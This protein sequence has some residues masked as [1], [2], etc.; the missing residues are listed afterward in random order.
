MLRP[1]I[2]PLRRALLIATTALA[3]Y[4]RP[5][6]QGDTGP[7]GGGSTGTGSSSDT[8][9][10]GDGATTA[11]DDTGGPATCTDDAAC[12]DGSVCSDDRCVAGAC[13][14]EP[15][16]APGCT[17]AAVDDC[18]Q[19]PASDECR[20][21]QCIDGACV[22]ELADLGTA[23]PSSQQQDGD[24]QRAVCDGLGGHVSET[25]DDDVPIDGLECTADRCTAGTPSNPPEDPTAPC[26][27]GTCDGAG[28]CTGCTAASECGDTVGVCEALA[29]D[30]G[31]CTVAHLPS[32][33][34]L[35]DQTAGDCVE[36]RCDGRG[37]VI[38]IAVDDPPTDDGSGCSTVSC[39]DGRAVVSLAAADVP[40][41]DG[42]CDGGGSCVACNTAAQ[43]PPAAAACTTATC[44]DHVCGFDFADA[45]VPC[46]DGLFCTLDDACDGGGACVGTGSP[47]AGAD[48]DNN[49]NESCDEANDN[50]FGHDPVDSPCN[51]AA[52]CTAIDRCNAAGVCVGV[53]SP[54]AG[55]D[56]DP[57]CTESCSEDNDDCNGADPV[58]TDCGGMCNACGAGGICH[59]YQPNECP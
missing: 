42:V 23:L 29:C 41:D 53:G 27:A 7:H 18:T 8:G 39:V 11:T 51:D 19:L 2:V 31:V 14:H 49:C 1:S 20:T 26:S 17:C 32:D 57:D 36:L 44:T 5:P 9:G 56:G 37:G 58:G 24:C 6:G 45:G 12:D 54:C 3:C 59:V 40:C 34:V 43:C 4:Q 52:F 15:N 38:A 50:C 28:A 13:V 46:D 47:C 25:D 55:P 33:T 10:S 35:P 22:L 48:G 16:A 21:R 30:D